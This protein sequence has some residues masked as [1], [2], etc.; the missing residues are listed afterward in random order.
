LPSLGICGR[1]PSFKIAAPAKQSSLATGKFPRRTPVS[2]LHMPSPV[3]YV[4]DYIIKLCRQ[5]AEVIQNHENENVRD[6]GKGE[7]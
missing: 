4:Y 1:H 7:A 2:E 6:I 3:S 5:K